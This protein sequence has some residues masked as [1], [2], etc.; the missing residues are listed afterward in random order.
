MF[1]NATREEAGSQAGMGQRDKAPPSGPS[2]GPSSFIL[3]YKCLNA[4]IT[5][6]NAARDSRLR[7]YAESR[8]RDL[9]L[10]EWIGKTVPSE[11]LEGLAVNLVERLASCGSYIQLQEIPWGG[12]AGILAGNFCHVYH[13]C[14]GCAF[15]R[16]LRLAHRYQE[17]FWSVM[18][19]GNRVPVMLTFTV[20][21]GSD[22][23]E[24][25]QHLRVSLKRYRDND[26]K[27]R[28]RGEDRLEISKVLGMVGQI[29]CKRGKNSGEWHPHF[30]AVGILSDYIDVDKFRDEWTK[31]TGDSRQVRVS[32]IT[33]DWGDKVQ[34]MGAFLECFKYPI[35]IGSLSYEDLW[36]AYCASFK[37]VMVIA[38]GE[39]RGVRVPDGMEESPEQDAEV[40][41][42]REYL[43]EVEGWKRISSVGYWNDNGEVMRRAFPA[44]WNDRR[45]MEDISNGD[46]GTDGLRGG[47]SEGGP[48]G[49]VSGHRRGDSQGE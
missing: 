27:R 12:R 39:F 47:V 16:G 44:D 37:R 22:L 41:F 35:K 20:K 24:R 9:T 4:D 36:T 1:Q 10:L 14:P 33:G 19:Q 6:E 30:H 43:A 5:S 21:D 29:E 13:L 18:H 31:I 11:D 34:M 28:D 3:D 8:E 25:V 17:K 26:R 48:L 2:R 15:F 40:Y 49:S 7:R 46:S 38:T 42:I 23:E 45:C 32:Q